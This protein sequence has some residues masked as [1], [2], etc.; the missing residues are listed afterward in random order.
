MEDAGAG[1]TLT[2]HCESAAAVDAALHG[3][4]LSVIKTVFQGHA[5]GDISRPN[6]YPPPCSG[7]R[8]QKN[9]FTETPLR[10]RELCSF[11]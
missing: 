3:L 5:N 11:S 9:R 8:V 2:T 4:V 7:N 1:A 10:K 6:I